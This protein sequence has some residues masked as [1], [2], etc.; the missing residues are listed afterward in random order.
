[1]KKSTQETSLRDSMLG[2]GKPKHK[3]FHTFVNSKLKR[4]RS[5]TGL[6]EDRTSSTAVVRLIV[7]LLL[8]H[9]IIIG[10]VLARGQLIKSNSGLAVSPGV[11]AP[12]VAPPAKKAEPAA[13]AKQEAPAPVNMTT[14]LKPA[15]AAQPAAQPA[16]TPAP[17]VNHI[18]QAPAAQPAP[19]QPTVAATPAPQPAPAPANTVKV[20]HYVQSGDTWGRVAAQYGTSVDALKGANPAAAANVNLI[21][22]T[23]LEV[24]VAADSEAAK[25]VVAEKEKTVEEAKPKT[26]VVKR[27]ETLGGIANRNKITLK[28][29]M[30]L[31]NLT[32]K[33]TRRIRPGME[34]KVSE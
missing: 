6:V 9:L 5:D 23:Y 18:T 7:G 21:S 34:L 12:P 2:R 22:G 28:K 24:P 27:G 13:P 8:V 31:N 33:D 16:A 14:V 4:H 3:R 17:Q 26:H 1:M 30:Q 20:N 15:P 10:G 25:A 32:P 19:V 29:L 11:T